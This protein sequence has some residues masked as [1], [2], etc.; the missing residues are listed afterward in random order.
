[1]RNADASPL[2]ITRP[3]RVIQGRTLGTG[4]RKPPFSRLREK[5]P[6]GRM[7]AGARSATGARGRSASPLVITRLVRVIQGRTLGTGRHIHSPAPLASRRP[8]LPA[9]AGNDGV[10]G[11]GSIVSESNRPHAADRMDDAARLSVAL[12]RAG[13][14]PPFRPLLPRVG[15]G[16]A[17]GDTFS[18]A[19]GSA[20]NT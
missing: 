17:C 2:V 9:F 12:T 3:V 14:H 8:G 20:A 11:T 16:G 10:K 13:P 1:M 18:G 15:E 6:E 5:V 19:F 4:R 7:R